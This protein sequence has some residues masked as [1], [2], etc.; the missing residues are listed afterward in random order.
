MADNERSDRG[1][2]SV[3]FPES[4]GIE[5]AVHQDP[6]M[7]IGAD[8]EPTEVFN[9]FLLGMKVLT[10][11]GPM[12]VIAEIGHLIERGARQSM[13]QR[14]KEERDGEGVPGDGPSASVDV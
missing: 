13:E 11:R 12:P 9:P 3:P 14:A 1:Y 5:A 4:M 7:G 10:I 8:G 6:V 2:V